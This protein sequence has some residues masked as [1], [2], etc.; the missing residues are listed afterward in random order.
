MSHWMRARRHDMTDW[1][2]QFLIL[3]AVVFLSRLG[4]G[5]FSGAGTN[6]FVD[7]LG[8]SGTQVL[9]VN[10]VR[11][12]P[13]LALM[14]IAALICTLPLTHR[15]ALSLL[16]LGVGY[17]L[18]ATVNSFG[19]LLMMTVIQSVGFHYWGPVQSSLGLAMAD[20]GHSGRMLGNLA[21]AGALASILGLGLVSLLGARVSLRAFYVL[22]ALLIVL[23]AIVVLRLPKTLGNSGERREPRLLLKK[24]YWLYYVLN[25]FEG[26]RT[27]VFGAFGTLVLVQQYGLGVGHI[28]GLLALSGLFNF[29]LAPY[30]GR[31]IDR[32][33]EHSVLSASYVA[34][35]IC[36][37]GYATIH[38]AAVL[39]AILVAINILLTVRIGLSSYVNRIAPPEELGPT[40][41]AGVSMNH[42][43]SVSV[44]FAAG[45]LLEYLGY[46]AICWGVAGMLLLS[47]PFAL[48]M[49]REITGAPEPL[50]PAVG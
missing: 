30:L 37:V 43:S 14:F 9:W 50:Q 20:K 7:T 21:A 44:S 17:G 22:G 16:L 18:Y 6:F 19:A 8:L 45:W 11:E 48:A 36:F 47:V 42:I 15:A 39:A 27:Q 46:E 25:F 1:N 13:G 4:Q 34:M 41:S 10:G 32:H 24:R 3:A 26:S 33:G 31:L 2:N 28:S 12:I 40:L 38:K 29:A 49:R 35:A 23:A 5:L